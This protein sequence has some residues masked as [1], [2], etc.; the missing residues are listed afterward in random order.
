MHFLTT[1]EQFWVFCVL[2]NG[3]Q[4]FKNFE[5]EQLSIPQKM[6]LEN[7]DWRVKEHYM[8]FKLKK[9][10]KRVIRYMYY[11]VHAT[12]HKTNRISGLKSQI[13]KPLL[14]A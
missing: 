11:Y 9:I 2:A 5:L 1:S 3:Y 7:P 8:E 12:P 10:E 6:L 14:L 13:L 4:R